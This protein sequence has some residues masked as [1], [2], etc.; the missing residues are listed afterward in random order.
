[1]S[2]SGHCSICGAAVENVQHVLRDCP[3][4]IDLW[5]QIVPVTL[6]RTFC[7]LDGDRWLRWN[8]CNR[9][10]SKQVDDW[11][12]IFV[13]TCWWAWRRHNTRV[14]EG[15]RVS[16]HAITASVN[17]IRISLTEAQSRFQLVDGRRSPT[18][19]KGH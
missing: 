2:V 11:K 13:I 6:W 10:G 9:G 14:F 3:E 4:T 8:L 5:R 18:K 1:M 12:L 19:E 17:A 15:K 7:N 16:N